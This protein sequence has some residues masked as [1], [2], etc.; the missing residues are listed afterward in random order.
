M[1]RGFWRSQGES[2]RT[3]EDSGQ[4]RQ[5]ILGGSLNRGCQMSRSEVL[6]SRVVPCLAGPCRR[7]NYR[8]SLARCAGCKDGASVPNQQRMA[9]N[10]QTCFLAK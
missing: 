3:D 10:E 2:I 1:P 9:A 6:R 8:D 4:L 5:A 7:S